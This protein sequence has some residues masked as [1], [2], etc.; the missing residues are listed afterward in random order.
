MKIREL[1]NE[2]A[3]GEYVYH[4]SYLPNLKM[5]L[6]SILE[7][8]LMPSKTGYSG[9]GVYFAYTPDGGF[10]HVDEED[11]TMFRVKWSDLVRLFGEFPK[12]PDGIQRTD[13][14]IIVPLTVPANILEVEY[15]KGEWWDL[16]SAYE[17]SRGPRL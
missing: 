10:Y 17:A 2:K 6:K 14:E 4:A 15:F 9:P 8:G 12:N 1:L 7:K 13:D 16:D 5:G 11:A 3:V